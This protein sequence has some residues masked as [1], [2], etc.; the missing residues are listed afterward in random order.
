ESIIQNLLR[1]MSA[2]SYHIPVNRISSQTRKTE[3]V[4]TMV[5]TTPTS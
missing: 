5:S 3:P 1:K 2:H 4:T